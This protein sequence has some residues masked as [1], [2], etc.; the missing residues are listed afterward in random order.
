MKT[1]VSVFAQKFCALA[2]ACAFVFALLSV[3]ST[4]L[5]TAYQPEVPKEL[6]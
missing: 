3:N 6:I 5:F 4:C 2:C 1:V